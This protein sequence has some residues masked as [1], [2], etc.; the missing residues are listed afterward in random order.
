MK[1]APDVQKPGMFAPPQGLSQQIAVGAACTFLV[2]NM[3]G[4]ATTSQATRTS[5]VPCIH[6]C[7]QAPPA[8]RRELK[9]GNATAEVALGLRERNEMRYDDA[10][11]WFRQ[12]AMQGNAVG[13]FNVGRDY[14]TGQG[15]TQDFIK[16]NH[17][18]RNAAD[19]GNLAA[20]INLATDYYLGRGIARS[21]I[22]AHTWYRK[23][24]DQGD[25]NAQYRVG[26]DYQYGKGVAQD[27][28][29]ANRWYR[30]AAD[31]GL[32]RAQYA[33][34]YNYGRGFGT[35][36]NYA[37]ANYWFR[38]AAIRG[39]PAAEAA[40]GLD[41]ATGRGCPIDP[42]RGNFWL[43]EAAA[44]GA[45][46]AEYI[47]GA[48]YEMGHGV[49]RN[50]ARGQYW[51]RKAAIQGFPPAEAALGINYTLGRG[52]A[53]NY[54]KAN[55]WLRKAAARNV[56]LAEYYLGAAYYLGRGVSKNAAE[57]HGW[58]Q[59]AKAHGP[60]RGQN[61]WCHLQ[62]R[63]S[64]FARSYNR[65]IRA[66]AKDRP[67]GTSPPR[68]RDH[69]PLTCGFYPEISQLIGQ[70]GTAIVRICIGKNGQLT[71]KPSLVRSSGV[72]RLDT[73]ALHFA[74][75]TSGQWIPA[76]VHGK[77]ISVCAKWPVRFALSKRFPAL[78]LQPTSSRN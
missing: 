76:Q 25:R 74:Q 61:T 46:P 19:Q 57:A 56:A 63:N 29:N 34:G 71:G 5:S 10:G 49:P 52:T 14:S 11:F 30:R 36:R 35:R 15:E 66:S 42:K 48:N 27:F 24:A 3:A 32:A 28:A 40:L 7:L 53:K 17:W 69:F 13:E 65:A 37:T 73:A 4:C 16:A 67:A 68:V 23:A 31:R 60:L 8:L 59:K 43:R 55:I 9:S 39:L 58:W 33:L 1:T 77:P 12:A 62:E 6:G 18:Y 22:K 26:L 20:E 2:L 64:R 75:A 38:K 78:G 41:Y 47:L 72:P 45:L 21:D 70:Q 44:Q 50:I 51:V 54:Q